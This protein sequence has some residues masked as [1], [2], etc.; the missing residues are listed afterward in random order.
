MDA[1]REAAKLAVAAAASCSQSLGFAHLKCNSVPSNYEE[2]ICQLCTHKHPWLFRYAMSTTATTEA[3]EGD[4]VATGGESEPRAEATAGACVMPRRDGPQREQRGDDW[5][6]VGNP[7]V[8]EGEESVPRGVAVE[9]GPPEAAALW[10]EDDGALF[11]EAD[12]RKKLCS[13]PTC[14]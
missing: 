5:A 4:S 2:M 7:L 10:E 13:C 8:P 6:S 14:Q 1:A 11:F 9:G 12:W 3:K